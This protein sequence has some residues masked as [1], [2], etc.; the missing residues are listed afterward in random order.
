MQHML[1]VNQ[2][3]GFQYWDEK[4]NFMNPQQMTFKK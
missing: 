2:I 1:R 4:L 3:L